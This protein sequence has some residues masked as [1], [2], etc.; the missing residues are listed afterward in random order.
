MSRRPASDVTVE[1]PVPT[2]TL[3]LGSRTVGTTRLIP[4]VNA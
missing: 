3:A 4:E 2:R 1:G